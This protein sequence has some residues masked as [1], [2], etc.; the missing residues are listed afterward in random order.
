MPTYLLLRFGVILEPK[1]RISWL[2]AQ[3]NISELLLGN[4]KYTFVKQYL[5]INYLLNY[6]LFIY[7]FSLVRVTLHE[8]P[9]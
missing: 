3:F 9:F 6:Q 5:S 1:A 2:G 7:L 4:N 8:Y